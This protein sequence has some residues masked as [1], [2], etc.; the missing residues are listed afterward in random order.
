M[1]DDNTDLVDRKEVLDMAGSRRLQGI[2]RSRGRLMV[3]FLTLPLY[4]IAVVM[5]L[6]RGRGISTL[7][8][9]YM[10]V[11]AVFAVDMSARVCP[12]CGRQFFVKSF[13]LNFFARRCVHCGLS[14]QDLAHEP[15]RTF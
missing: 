14:K 4:V 5:L 6:D 3:C 2:L 15:G 9:I 10:A 13:F 12:R 1:K 8:F 7:M 11:Y